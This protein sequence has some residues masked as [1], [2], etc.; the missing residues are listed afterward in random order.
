MTATQRET[1]ADAYLA[2]HGQ[3]LDLIDA[4]RRQVEDMPS[5]DAPGL[6]WAHVGDL[7]RLAAK[8]REL[9]AAE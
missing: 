9:T 2:R 5:P 1:L 6:N 7:E 4:I 8:L 3:A